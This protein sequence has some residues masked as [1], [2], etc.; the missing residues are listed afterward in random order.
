MLEVNKYLF[1]EA[2][3]ASKPFPHPHKP[4]FTVQE[5]FMQTVKIVNETLDRVLK[6][7]KAVEETVNDCLSKITTDNVNFKDMTTSTY[8]EFANAVKNELNSFESSLLN[9]YQAFKDSIELNYSDF[10]VKYDNF[11]EQ[12]NNIT[13]NLN[14]SLTEKMNEHFARQDVKIS[15]TEQYFKSNFYNTV[16]GSL[17]EMRNDGSL[18]SAISD[19]VL[20]NTLTKEEYNENVKSLATK[21]ELAVERARINELTKLP[22]GS[23]AGDAELQDIRVGA[24]GVTRASAGASV[25]EQFTNLNNAKLNK[26]DVSIN[27][28]SSTSKTV[29]QKTITEA[30]DTLALH[31]SNAIKTSVTGSPITVNDASTLKHA[32]EVQYNIKNLLKVPY[33]DTDKIEN[34]VSFTVNSDY[35][36]SVSGTAEA[37]TYFELC[38]KD[39]GDKHLDVYAGKL[40]ANGYVI[41]GHY[42]GY[43]YT[44]QIVSIKIPEGEAVNVTIYPQIEKGSKATD[45]EAPVKLSEIGVRVCGRNLIPYPYMNGSY[46]TKGVEFTDN[47]DGS[48]T[49]VGTATENIWFNLYKGYLA[50]VSIPS[51]VSKGYISK[52][53]NYNATNGITSIAI[54]KG[55]TVNKTFY[56]YI[57]IGDT[58]PEFEKYKSGVEN[59][60]ILPFPYE[61]SS[62]TENGI[63][64]T[65]NEDKSITVNGTATTP[66]YFN[67]AT[68]ELGSTAIGFNSNNSEYYLQGQAVQ[69]NPSNGKIAMTVGAGTTYENYRFTPKLY[70]NPDKY[71]K[72]YFS[73]D[74]KLTFKK[75]TGEY[76]SVIVDKP[77]FSLT[78]HYNQDTE[79]SIEE[80]LKSALSKTS[81]LNVEDYK[82]PVLKLTGDISTMTKDNEVTLEYVYGEKTGACNM[83]WQGSSSIQYP[84]KN[85]TIKF[86]ETFEASNGWGEQKKYCL[87][88]NYIDFSHT[89]NLVSAK[90]WG[91]IVRSRE[92]ERFLNLPNAGAVDGF[93]ICL[94]INGEYQGIYTFNIPKDKW[95][96]GMGSGTSEAI[97]TA[98]A[99]T[100]GTRFKS[101]I[102][103]DGSDFEI[104]HISADEDIYIIKDRLNELIDLCINAD[105]STIDELENF[106]DFDSAIDYLIFTSLIQGTD[107]M[108]KNYILAS[109]DYNKW[110]ISAYDMDSTYGLR[111]DGLSILPA[112]KAVS[113]NDFANEHLLMKLILKYKKTEL[114]ARYKE[115]RNTILSEDNV[116]TLFNNFTGLI[117]QILFNEEVKL[118]NNLRNTS[119]SNVHQITS[120]Y[121]RRCKY[122]DTEIDNL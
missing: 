14:N 2:G 4:V 84:K 78:L 44:N 64:F 66:T 106:I 121:E 80:K 34:G 35:S 62:K 112:N 33:I 56:P 50:P 111:W 51:S 11:V 76:I 46:K 86:D 85:F 96:F 5:E 105:A 61:D 74:D 19:T 115:L 52:D 16:K 17:N 23:T 43:N 117:P 49:V 101:D 77:N 27:L 38:K 29:S 87:K 18:S 69:Y 98:E 39:F 31:S 53:C 72:Q 21:T 95:M 6:L 10:Q 57:G 47:G 110:Y 26:T 13:E 91:Q 108:T 119:V 22:S 65:V 9:A 104:E 100:A 3:P 41:S 8:N 15:E 28:G 30:I 7:E 107:M 60:N 118:W 92:N 81:V 12:V 1:P 45:Y 37:D 90:L 94:I 63:T 88:A 113:I 122:I 54:S 102:L 109:Y 58:M 116:I 20:S 24:D 71:E 67:I 89:R 97:I 25:R 75:P 40:T 59:E 32:V 93:P 82:L 73:E 83:K 79:K 120:W 55:Q 99:H 70:L 68:M 42:V 48:I 103:L 36:I 114:K